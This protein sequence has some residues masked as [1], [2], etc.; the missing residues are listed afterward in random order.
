MCLWYHTFGGWWWTGGTTLST[1][2]TTFLGLVGQAA[3][4]LA[5]ES[6]VYVDTH[7]SRYQGLYSTWCYHSRNCILYLLS[8]I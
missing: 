7:Y 8:F 3:Q 1:W 4:G 2:R 5:L 6:I